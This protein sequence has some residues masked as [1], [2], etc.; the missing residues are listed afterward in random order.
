M[1]YK[2][3]QVRPISSKVDAAFNSKQVIKNCLLR[4]VLVLAIGHAISGEA[5]DKTKK[6]HF[7]IPAKDL[8][9][10]LLVYSEATGIQ[11]S[12]PQ[13][14][15]SDIK[16][17]KVSGDYT[18]EQ[19]LQQLLNDSGI[20]FQQVDA[21][22]IA[23]TQSER[24]ADSGSTTLKPMTVVGNVS[25]DSPSLTTPSLEQSQAK[26]KRVPGGTTV[27][28]GERLKEGAALTV[29]DAL[30]MAPGVYVGDSQAGIAG[31]SQISIRGSNVNSIFSPIRGIKVLRNGIP[32]TH[33]TGSTDTESINL[34]AIDHIDIYRGANA[35][36]YGGSNL[37]GAINYITPTAYTADP[38]KVGMAWGTNGY[39][40]PTVSGGKVFGNGFDAYGSFAYL[41]TDTTRENNEQEQFF[42][43]GNAGYRWNDKQETRLYVDIQN[44][45]YLSAGALTKQQIKENPHQNPNSWARTPTGFSLYRVDLKHSIQ[46]DD[47]D[48]FD[49]GTYYS[50]KQYSFAYDFGV[51]QDL[52]QDAGVNWRHEINSHLFGL[53]NKVVW[54]GLSQWTFINDN[55]YTPNKTL[56]NNA[57]R[58]RWLN[59]EGFMEDQLSL[60]DAFTLVA[61]VQLNYRD[62][63]YERI[64]GYVAN[65]ARPSKQANQDFFNANPKLGFTWQATEDAQ[66]YGNLSRSSE[67]T[68]LSDLANLFITPSR[69][70]QTGSTV[71]I[72]TRGQKDRLK[73]DLAFYQAWLNN[74]Y[75][76]IPNPTN[77]T[78][79]TAANA[80]STTLHTGVEL[81]LESTLPLNLAASGDQVRLSGNY[82]WNNFRF[83]NDAE[84]RDNQLPGTPEHVA[85][86]EALY[87]HPSGFYV[88]PNTQIVSTNWV[89]FKNTLSAK[90]YALLGARIGWDDGK[91]WK[92]YVDGRN[93]TDEHYASSVWVMANARGADWDKFNPGM[94]RSVFGGVEYRF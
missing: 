92:L 93:L 1:K 64:V 14:L 33:A 20:S 88:G 63:N 59:V 36:E 60:T 22:V 18:A 83:E 10:A 27:I 76:I 78:V 68:P 37:G 73:W 42:G 23:L 90:P 57:E 32:Y 72:G 85:R 69:V 61:G 13:A 12:Y 46:L 54:G 4:G 3:K 79:F 45:D 50:H 67:P 48:Q 74:E 25:P 52:W 53:K 77:P 29:T 11:L 65:A 81:G 15:V 55:N 19:A 24:T 89:D 82:T 49:V 41:N 17:Q 2:V 39:V 35:L 30:A 43:H 62:V 87:Q 9:S 86:L 28:D 56:L 8:A 31:G 70:A 47:G 91:H 21:D 7:D 5:A 58:D 71:E 40:S 94:T 34:Y 16:S 84:Y 75:L 51:F 44:H 26:L 38:L 80:N 66:I 6:I